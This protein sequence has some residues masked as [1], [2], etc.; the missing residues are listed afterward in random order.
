MNKTKLNDNSVIYSIGEDETGIPIVVTKIA[1]KD[2]PSVL[3]VTE[4]R[5]RAGARAAMRKKLVIAGPHG[6]E[7]SAQRLIMVA[8]K[9]FICHGPPPD[10]VMYF[11]PCLSPTM[12]FA[13]ARGIP[14]KFWAEGN[15]DGVVA[16]ELKIGK[17]KFEL[18][19]GLQI[20]ALHNEIARNTADEDTPKEEKYKYII[21]NRMQREQKNPNKPEWGVDSNR[22]VTRSY[23]S[24]E[25]FYNFI[26]RI[27][28]QHRPYLTEDDFTRTGVDI[29][30]PQAADLKQT[31]RKFEGMTINDMR[32]LMIH[33]YDDSQLSF[34]NEPR[35]CIYGPYYVW[36][37]PRLRGI[38]WP[39]QMSG[40]DKQYVNR[41]RMAAG[42]QEL[43][44]NGKFLYG[45]TAY[46]AS[47]YEG[48]WS[49]QLKGKDV[50]VWSADIELPISKYDEG[51]RGEL[52]DRQYNFR[53][54]DEL[55][56]IKDDFIKLLRKF[57]WS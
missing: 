27:K 22:D 3:Q 11:I 7:R 18:I 37:K 35:G 6:D 36:E 33:G 15:G 28:Q 42:W 53:K 30:D 50:Y 26:R 55:S 17:K 20:P 49:W 14:N 34:H 38:R 41:I 8:Q 12:A 9:H 48:E 19:P 2:G 51:V 1:G 43:D 40:A 39:A 10:T 46:D 56:N 13:D 44:L 47:E 52:S 4:E 16:M 57:P 45:N 21:R 32:V 5:G 24:S 29:H 25:V 54:I 23:K 31:T